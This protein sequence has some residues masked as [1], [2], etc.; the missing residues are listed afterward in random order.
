MLNAFLP[1]YHIYKD[2]F[3]NVLLKIHV[4][5]RLPFLHFNLKHGLHLI[6]SLTGVMV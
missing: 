3:S 1:S 4:C 5:I 6:S 2:C